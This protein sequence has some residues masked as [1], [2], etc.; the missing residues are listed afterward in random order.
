MLALFLKEF[1]EAT[2]PWDRFRKHGGSLV[3][4]RTIEPDIFRVQNFIA[5]ENPYA[6]IKTLIF[7]CNLADKHK[8][9]ITGMAQP[10]LVG[11]SV[12]QENKFFVGL[13]KKRLIKL[14]K[15]Y[16]FESN[17]SDGR[18]TVIRRPKNED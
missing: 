5:I 17:E 7:T 2:T 6:A 14:Y 9:T 11:P 15:K 12:T 8:I 4:F 18:I 13:D 16:G 3:K 10:A 1:E